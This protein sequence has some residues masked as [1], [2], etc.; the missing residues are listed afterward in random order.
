MHLTKR[1]KIYT[2]QYRGYSLQSRAEVDKNQDRT[3]VN[4]PSHA[5]DRSSFC[6]SCLQ[7]RTHGGTGCP[8]LRYDVPRGAPPGGSPRRRRFSWRGG[9]GP[10]A[11]FRASTIRLLR[12]LTVLKVEGTSREEERVSRGK[13]RQL[14][15]NMRRE[16]KITFSTFHRPFYHTAAACTAVPIL[17]GVCKVKIILTSATLCKKT[18]TNTAA[19][20][21]LQ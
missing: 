18:K 7:T 20:Q 12:V 15:E 6:S 4:G 1:N 8:S 13:E 5:G 17:N 21:Y 14:A 2:V 16:T 10:R 19:V 9:F 3:L 11:P